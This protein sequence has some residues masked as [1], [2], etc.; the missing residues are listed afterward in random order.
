MFGIQLPVDIETVHITTHNLDIDY[1]KIVRMGNTQAQQRMNDDIKNLVDRMIKEQGYLQNPNITMWGSYEVKTNE[2]GVL[3]IN[4]INDAYSG[5][6]HGLTRMHGLTFDINTGTMYQLKD[7][8]KPNSNYQKIL[9]D[10]VRKQIKDRNIF[11]LGSFIGIKPNQDFYIGDKALVLYFQ[12]YELTSYA[13][14]FPS[15]PIS[16]YEIENIINHQ[17]PLGKMIYL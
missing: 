5:G 12:L 8:F 13:F 9:S 7:L 17:S 15:F 4:L 1:P 11:L 10:I 3:S 6:A 16:V 2:R 14:G